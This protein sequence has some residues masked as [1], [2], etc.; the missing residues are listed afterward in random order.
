MA[1]EN[2]QLYEEA[3]DRSWWRSG[4][5]TTAILAGTGTEELLALVVRHARVAGA[6]LATLARPAG[7]GRLTV[8]AADGL[9]AEQHRGTMF[10]AEGSVTGEVIRTG[11]AVVLADASADER[12]VQPLSEPG[13]GRR[14][15][16]PWPCATPS[17]AP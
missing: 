10:A 17:S 13:S 1:I 11:K 7:S 6:D 16:S 8:E 4:D 9:L 3:R 15:S 12:V 2:A 14:C 5:I